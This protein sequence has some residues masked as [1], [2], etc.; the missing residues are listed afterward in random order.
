M[1]LNTSNFIFVFLC[2]R[3]TYDLKQNVVIKN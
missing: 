2:K 3:N 1:L